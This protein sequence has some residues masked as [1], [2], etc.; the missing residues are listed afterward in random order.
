MML[1]YHFWA[2]SVPFTWGNQK[3]LKKSLLPGRQ[4]TE[5]CDGKWE[6][7][8]SYYAF[9]LWNSPLEWDWTKS[10]AKVH[11][12][13]EIWNKNRFY[14]SW[15]SHPLLWTPCLHQ[16]GINKTNLSFT[17]KTISKWQHSTRMCLRLSDKFMH[18]SWKCEHIRAFWNTT[19][20]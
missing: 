11:G 3:C 12:K 20:H 5:S 9:S 8:K 6:S 15:T 1:R 18:R 13:T 4:K 10:N 16:S 2:H 14:G 7:L 17:R 19:Q